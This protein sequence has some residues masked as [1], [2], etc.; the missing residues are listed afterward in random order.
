[1]SPSDTAPSPQPP[2]NQQEHHHQQVIVPLYAAQWKRTWHDF[3]RALRSPQPFHQWYWIQ[4][5]VSSASKYVFGATGLQH[6]VS[7]YQVKQRLQSILPAFGITLVLFIWWS[8]LTTFRPMLRQEWCHSTTE[9][10][11]RKDKI[12]STIVTYLIVMIAW[13]FV[14]ACFSSPGVAVPN[15]L[16]VTT[17]KARNAQGG[18]CCFNPPFH[19]EI[20][21]KRVALY[22][23]ILMDKSQVV[24]K[25]R[26]PLPADNVA[27]EF[28]WTNPS[29]CEICD[30]I[31]PPR[32][33]HCK[34]CNRCTLQVS[35]L[36]MNKFSLVAH[37]HLTTFI[38][39]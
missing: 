38:Y 28:P 33:H 31:R 3:N 7:T 14:V 5:L 24:L 15:S 29:Y 12:H 39:T 30:I 19:V 16:K 17:W 8:Y 32:C 23:G 6:F 21:R 10:Y 27:W 25:G 1:M 20:E 22:D 2:S 4:Q 37:D 13:H 9:S 36:R 35:L 11:C 34:V 18:F 26:P